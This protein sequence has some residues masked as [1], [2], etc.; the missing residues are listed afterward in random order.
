MR[1][2]CSRGVLGGLT[3]QHARRMRLPGIG[4]LCQKTRMSCRCPLFLSKGAPGKPSWA[5]RLRHSLYSSFAFRDLSRIVLYSP[6]TRA[7]GQ[8]RSLG[9]E[10]R[11]DKSRRL[12]LGLC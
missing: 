4:A 9:G 11:C 5:L 3:L 10:G 12:F 1:G 6:A 8:A 7:I 2:S